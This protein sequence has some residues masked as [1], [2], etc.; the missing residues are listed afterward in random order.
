MKKEQSDLR[1]SNGNEGIVKILYPGNNTETA[2]IG[3]VVISI[4]M[5]V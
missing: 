4:M 1:V 2:G 3:K 5:V